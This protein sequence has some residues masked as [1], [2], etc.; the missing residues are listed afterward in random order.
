MDGGPRLFSLGENRTQFEMHGLGYIY[1]KDS[2]DTFSDRD[3]I[4]GSQQRSNDSPYSYTKEPSVLSS[5]FSFFIISF[6]GVIVKNGRP[7]DDYST[8]TPV[9]GY[10]GGGENCIIS[11]GLA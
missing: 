1:S 10:I 7:F 2:L 9:M 5:S 4:S 11:L 8:S 6:D 3:V